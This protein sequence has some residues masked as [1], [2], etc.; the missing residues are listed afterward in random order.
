MSILNQSLTGAGLYDPRHDNRAVSGLQNAYA[1]ASTEPIAEIPGNLDA[2]EVTVSEVSSE[3]SMLVEKL[4]PL[5]P[6]PPPSANNPAKVDPDGPPMSLIGG[7][8]LQQTR[9]LH[10]V[11]NTLRDLRVM[12]AI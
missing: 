3:L 1:P 4:R 2:L 5:I 8:I 12:V 6:P 9:R 10:D 11:T 7:R